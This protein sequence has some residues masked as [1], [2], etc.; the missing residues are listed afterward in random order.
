MTC[1][2]DLPNELL[3]LIFPYLPLQALIA[4]TGVARLWRHLAP[5]SAL[6]PTRR[7]L[8]ELYHEITASPAFLPTR[9][10]ILPHLRPFDRAAYVAQLPAGISAEFR[11][12]LL[13]WPARATV[14]CIWPGLDAAFAMSSDAFA[15]RKGAS[16]GLL[17]PDVRTMTLDLCGGVTSVSCL[18]VYDEGNGWVHWLVLSGAVEGDDLGGAVYSKALERSGGY[19]G[20]LE[21]DGWS[22]Y[23]LAELE[24]EQRQLQEAGLLDIL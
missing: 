16:N 10:T 7:S 17:V 24:T 13:E 1:I 20:F 19:S 5:L 15:C 11:L 14:A 23:L 22:A 21:A 12:W 9:A 4:C 8:F 3:L 18:K 2:S 6:D